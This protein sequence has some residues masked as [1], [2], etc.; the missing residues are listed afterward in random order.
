MKAKL[1]IAIGAL[2]AIGWA[3]SNAGAAHFIK[4]TDA[5][6]RARPAGA[7]FSIDEERG[8]LIRVWINNAG[9]FVFVLDTGAGMNVISQRVVTQLRLQTKVGPTTVVGGL[10]S[11]RLT[12]NREAVIEKL[13]AGTAGNLL[14]S[15]QTALIVS[16]L[17]ADV[18]GIL[19][20]TE[21]Y[22]PFGYVID[23]PNAQITALDTTGLTQTAKGRERAVVSWV[24]K[25]GD[26]RPFVKLGDGRLA[27]VDTGSG[28]GLALND[29]N[30]VVIGGTGVNKNNGNTR[31]IAGGLIRSRRVQ[32]TTVSIG[33]LELRRIPTD[34]L[35]D[36]DR[37]APNILGRDALYPFKMSFDPTRGLIEFIA[38]GPND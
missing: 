11:A 30:A 23:M 27:L 28:F 14:A 19:D 25:P 37:N 22:A 3:A 6:E 38:M 26:N 34:I 1:F 9:P 35:F 4:P 21:A 32:P 10:S 8:L 33:E 31:D 20:P 12:S 17:P 2:A 7:R 18:D 13:S 5:I 36:A 24:R 29:R 16:N 15:K